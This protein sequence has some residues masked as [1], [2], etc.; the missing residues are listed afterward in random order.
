MNGPRSL[1]AAACAGGV[2]LPAWMA[3]A[4]SGT[5]VVPQ[6]SA[7][8]QFRRDDVADPGFPIAGTVLM[9]ALIAVGAGAWW[10]RH[11]RGGAWLQRLVTPAP[12]EVRVVSSVRLDVNTRLHVIEW[13]RRQLLVAVQGTAAPVVLDREETAAAPVEPAP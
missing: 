4:E 2:L 1:R 8:L 5:P 11:R 3:R 7:P 6:A 9:L 13:Q 12:T 10:V